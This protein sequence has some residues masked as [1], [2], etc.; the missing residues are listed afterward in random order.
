MKTDKIIAEKI[1]NV[2]K[3]SLQE[4]AEI[5]YAN[6]KRAFDLL[7]SEDL[8]EADSLAKE[9]MNE[10]QK[11]KETEN[12]IAEVAMSGEH[13]ITMPEDSVV[14]SVGEGWHHGV[15]GIVASKIT[16]QFYKPCILLSYDENGK[17]ISS[18]YYEFGSLAGTTEYTYDENGNPIEKK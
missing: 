8:E 5:T 3:F 17:M 2:K 10:N 1:A 13:L 11:R 12:E 4:I 6:A 18:R 14:I 16:E 9:L 15:I 7:I